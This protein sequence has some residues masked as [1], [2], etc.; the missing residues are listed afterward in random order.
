M[1]LCFEQIKSKTNLFYLFIYLFI[2]LST[3][4]WMCF[5][6]FW[7]LRQW[8]GKHFSAR[9]ADA[10]VF[11]NCFVLN[12]NTLY[13]SEAFNKTPVTKTLQG[14]VRE[15]LKLYLTLLVVASATSE[16]TFSTLLFTKHSLIVSLSMWAWSVH[17]DIFKS[18]GNCRESRVETHMSRVETHM[19]RV[20]SN[21]SRVESNMSRVH[22]FINR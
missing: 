2:Y 9:V 1:C 14:E 17:T 6:S 5:W 3:W 22:N 11:T 12:I 16:R 20:E 21:M 18:L 10:V 13:I 15:L 19:S 4:L 7:R 8:S